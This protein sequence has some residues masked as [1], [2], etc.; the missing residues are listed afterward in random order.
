MP[1][2][3]PRDAAAETSHGTT[4]V[5]CRPR[6]DAGTADGSP[7]TRVIADRPASGIR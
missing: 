2:P 1:V 3:M 7:R 4:C 5:L 6:C